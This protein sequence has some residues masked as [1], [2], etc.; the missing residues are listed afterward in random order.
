MAT[1][2]EL[3]MAPIHGSQLSCQYLY[4][5]GRLPPHRQAWIPYENKPTENNTTK[6]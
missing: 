6:E 4:E 5:H 1:I 2:N 3:A